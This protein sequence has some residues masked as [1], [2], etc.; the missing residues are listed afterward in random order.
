[1][2]YFENDCSSLITHLTQQALHGDRDCLWQLLELCDGNYDFWSQ[3][4]RSLSLSCE[5]LSLLVT[6]YPKNYQLWHYI[7]I[8]LPVIEQM[9]LIQQALRLDP[10]NYHAW[11]I[12]G[13][14]EELVRLMVPL[15]RRLLE[16]DRLN[17][18]ARIF[19]KNFT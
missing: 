11:Q 16:Q 18:S 15:A 17:N 13:K 10:K 1:M 2:R 7:S 8:K 3:A 4:C 6:Q 9:E 12:S 19:L 14:E 5:E